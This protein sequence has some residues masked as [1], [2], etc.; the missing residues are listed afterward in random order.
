MSSLLLGLL[1]FVVAPAATPKDSDCLECHEK[2]TGPAAGTVHEG[3][4]CTDC[5]TVSLKDHPDTP[6]PAVECGACHDDVVRD[7]AASVHGA[8][9]G[10]S[11][12]ARATCSS[13][14][15][16]AHAILPKT[17][18]GSKTAK[19][20]LP[21][22][23]GGCHA[24]PEFLAKHHVPFAHPVESYKLSVHGRAVEAGNEKAATCSDCHGSHTIRPARDP[25]SP[26]N[27]WNV[28][29][30]CAQCHGEIAK[31]YAGS[32]HGKA[33]AESV[34]GAPV[35]TDC[36]G[37]HAI[38]APSEPG[39][40]VNPAR[41]SSVTCGRCHGDERLAARYNRPP[42]RCSPSGTASTGWR[43]ARAPDRGQLRILPRRPRH[44]AVQGPALEGE[45]ANLA[46]TCGACHPGAGS[47]FAL[48]PIHVREGGATEQPIV[49]WIRLF[50]LWIIPSPW[51][52]WCSTTRWTSSQAG[53]GRAHGSGS[54]EQVPRMNWHFR[55]AHA[56]TVLSFPILVVTGFALKYPELVVGASAGGMG[57]DPACP[58]DRPPHR[59]GVML[60]AAPLHVV[61]S[62]APPPRARRCCGT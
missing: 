1:L 23:C 13:C 36:H 15:G 50:Y 41:V 37:E 29:H 39:S 62:A 31:T 7:L 26:I 44:P 53:S 22:T 8:T 9:D 20:N 46:K 45:S 42:G 3:L 59:R 27:H 43:C 52:S 57:G 2:G 58:R 4:S 60:A 55:V 61:A 16:A 48:G 25:K 38:L 24:N 51:A 47:R 49:R 14:H 5:H 34:P 33:V 28:V 35:C 56:L 21:A 18:P 12:K 30:T 19:K 17:D 11:G 10:S 32:V 6:P 54:R 40:L